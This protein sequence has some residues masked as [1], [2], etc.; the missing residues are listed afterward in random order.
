MIL[1]PLASISFRITYALPDPYGGKVAFAVLIGIITEHATHLP[2]D[3]G[4]EIA[5]GR[6]GCGFPVVATRETPS[7]PMLSVRACVSSSSAHRSP[8]K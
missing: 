5:Q 7:L 8:Q 3:L 2:H 1:L 4:E 6:K